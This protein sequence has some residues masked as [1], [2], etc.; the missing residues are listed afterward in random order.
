[1]PKGTHEKI[2]NAFFRCANK[3]PDVHHF[4]I[5]EIAEEAG[6]SRQAI[7][8]KHYKTVEELILD[9]RSQICCQIQEQLSSYHSSDEVSP[10]CFLALHVLPIIYTRRDWI[11]VLCTTCMD[12]HWVQTLEK[13]YQEWFSPFIIN[14]ITQTGF[15]PQF[16]KSF[17]AKEVLGIW[18]CWLSE[19]LPAPP[20]S[21]QKNFLLLTS[22]SEKLFIAPQYHRKV[23]E[24]EF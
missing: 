17:I 24:K 9:I 1:M 21:F 22:S 10:Y 15:S 4:T 6:V 18:S 13:Q 12:P 19:D 3:Y 5:S 2:I 16:V 23:Q 14:N 11:K 7:Q 8:R 20:I